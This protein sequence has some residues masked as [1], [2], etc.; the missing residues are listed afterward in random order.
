MKCLNVTGSLT[1]RFSGSVKPLSAQIPKPSTASR[2]ETFG[3]DFASLE[4]RVLSW[5]IDPAS[6][7]VASPPSIGEPS[8]EP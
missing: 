7:I 6:G 8:P 4:L 1:G 3:L 2:V 5:S